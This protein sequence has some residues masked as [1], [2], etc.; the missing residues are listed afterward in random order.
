VIGGGV[1]GLLHVMLGRRLQAQ[2]VLLANRGARR[3]RNATA[4]GLLPES[5][6]VVFDESWRTSLEA[7]TGGSLLDGVVIAV[8]G[9]GPSF[10]ESL[11]PYLADGATVHL[12]GGFA[13]D[14]VIHTPGGGQLAAQP[15]RSGGQQTV[16][17]PGGRTCT[18]VG[19][20][21]AG[22][23]EF[24]SAREIL[25]A[26]DPPEPPFASLISH[27][28][29]LDAAPA[30]LAELAR[31]GCVHG[32]PALRVVV[33][34]RLRGRLVQPAELASPHRGVRDEPH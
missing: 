17:L 31:T 9:A 28:V 13:P 19:S 25:S 27:V 21:G 1:S 12:F 15:I 6:C 11:W 23:D 8:S 5:D 2:H 33:D 22:A 30:V 32:D 18:L 4:R 34:L 16:D 20:R 14:A 26:K 10:A 7:A 24:R 29:S 3:L